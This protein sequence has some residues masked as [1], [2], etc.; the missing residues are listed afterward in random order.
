MNNLGREMLFAVLCYFDLC[1]TNDP[2][3][4]MNC[5]SNQYAG[6]QCNLRYQFLY[7]ARHATGGCQTRKNFPWRLYKLEPGLIEKAHAFKK[8]GV[9]VGE[10]GVRTFSI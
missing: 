8:F 3:P 6:Q 9:A 4:G 2:L 7:V 5:G 1:I 10:H